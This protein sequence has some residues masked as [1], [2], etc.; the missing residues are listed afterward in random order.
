M[1]TLNDNLQIV[2]VTL[3]QNSSKTTNYQ[4]SNNLM[5]HRK[6]KKQKFKV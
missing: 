6:S 3:D 2:N 5:F 4:V 1:K